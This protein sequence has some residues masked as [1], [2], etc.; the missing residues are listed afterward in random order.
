MH[1]ERNECGNYTVYAE[2]CHWFAY[3]TDEGVLNTNGCASATPNEL[4]HACT[5]VMRLAQM[6]GDVLPYDSLV[7]A[8]SMLLVR[9]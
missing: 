2:Q 7:N 5:E 3:A 1:I 4:E 8:E 6:H 9:S